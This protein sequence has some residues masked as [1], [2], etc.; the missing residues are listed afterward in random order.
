MVNKKA[1]FLCGSGGS[2]K[3]TI[4]QKYFSDYVSVDVDIIYE[5]L[6]IESNLGLDIKKFNP[7]Q[8]KVSNS[9]FEK[10]KELNNIKFI[11]VLSSGENIIIDSI[12]RDLDGILYQRNIL[13]KSGYSTFM[14][15]VYADLDIC[16][17]RVENR[18]RSYHKSLTIDSW[19]KVYSN[20]VPFKKEFGNRF[21]LV[22]NDEPIDWK[23][24]F[25]IFIN[26]ESRKNT[27][28]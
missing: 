25:E 14:I 18:T 19:Y 8:I 10:A 23:S 5:Q 20:I 27:I 9:L 4:C 15:M 26:N 16:I 13:E 28:I 2:G 12:G 17:N 21:M 22:Y 3:S 1:I 24:K 6:L 11:D 7:E